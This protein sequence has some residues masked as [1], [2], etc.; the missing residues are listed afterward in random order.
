[1]AKLDVQVGTLIP[2]GTPSPSRV[3]SPDQVRS[4]KLPPML[5]ADDV[6]NLSKTVN[7]LHRVLANSTPEIGQI[8]LRNDAGQVVSAFGDA[9][10]NGVRY[11]NYLSELHVGD[12]L[13]T[14]DPAHA[15]LNA[16]TDGSVTIGQNGW[17]D[18]IDPFGASAAWLGT[19]NDTLPVTGAADN[20]FGN[21][22]LTVP[23][24]TLTTGN[25]V[26]SARVGG[27]P[28]ATGTF[29][30]TVV[31]TSQV[32]LDGSVWAGTYTSGGEIDRLLKVVGASMGT[33]GVVRIQTAVAH[34]YE[35][36]DRVNLYGTLGIPN[37]DGQWSVEVASAFQ[38]DCVG[39]VYSGAWVAGG[40]VLRYFAG[41]LAQTFATGASFANYSLRAFADGSL[42]I[43]NAAIEVT[44]NQGRVEIDPATAQITLTSVSSLA[45]IILDA[46]VPAIKLLDQTGTPTVTLEVLQESD[47][48]ISATDGASPDRLTL[49]T[50][51]T[52]VSGDTVLI[53]N[54]SGD[55]APN[56]YRIVTGLSAPGGTFTLT[57]LSGT[58]I[59]GNGTY[60]G[61]GRIRRYYA[62]LL[63]QTIALGTAFD[64][65]SLRAFADGTLE[66]NGASLTGTSFTDPAATR[67]ALSA[68]WAV[69]LTRT[70]PA[71]GHYVELGNLAWGTQKGSSVEV[72]IAF[73]NGST[74]GMAKKFIVTT[75][76]AGTSDGYWRVTPAS[77]SVYGS[78]DFDLIA[79]MKE[80]DS[81]LYL[82][83]QKTSGSTAGTASVHLAFNCDSGDTWTGTTGTG[84]TISTTGTL[85]SIVPV[86]TEN[87]IASET[88]A[89]NAI[90]G[91]LPGVT[92][93]AGLRVTVKLAHSLQVGANTFNLNAGGAVAI[94][95]A[96]HNGGDIGSAYSS[97][98]VVNLLY[99][100]TA[101]LDLSQFQGGYAEGTLSPDQRPS[102]GATNGGFL[103]WSTDFSLLYLWTGGAWELLSD[104][105][106]AWAAPSLLNSWTDI[107]AP[108]VSSAY[109][110]TAN[111]QVFVR[112]F[113][114]GGTYTDGTSVFTLPIGYRPTGSMIFPVLFNDGAI[115]TGEVIVDSAGDFKVYGLTGNTWL[116]IALSFWT[117]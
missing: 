54:C 69:D 22:R 11:T 116:Q 13:L 8:V 99:D 26:R 102:L 89:N 100:G 104:A 111:G 108:Y 2:R 20:G 48:V 103:F 57:D 4:G 90:A 30:I 67:T 35:T 34:G 16:N 9:V 14:H 42:R 10:Y 43:R 82:Y 15:L 53:Q 112:A 40:Y 36:G 50:A 87:Y 96:L 64:S 114:A 37:L 24:H 61:G 55:T 47:I 21:I 7:A 83:L 25:S 49:A 78:E 19:R 56:G 58:P 80:S 23:G 6:S 29:T 59:N 98:S 105:L 97:G 70:M 17:L 45:S 117:D 63:A 28:N 77:S 88:G 51:H 113:V 73:D 65:Y 27:V 106:G 3:S 68:Q 31:N 84:T 5:L 85:N 75:A 110:E 115:K 46:T 71:T 74:V 109:R 72:S 94:H 86:A 95:S 60:S 101:W 39:S 52:Y 1:M 32:D 33:G 66:L 107:G 92:L 62:G 18:I 79:R 93:V 44:S 12:P 91:A 81:K 38:F 76:W 41:M